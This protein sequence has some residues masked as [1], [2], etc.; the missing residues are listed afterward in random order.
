MIGWSRRIQKS[1]AEYV[2]RLFQ[3]PPPGYGFS[4]FTV[5][6]EEEVRQA[7]RGAF[8]GVSPYVFV[9]L[10]DLRPVRAAV[11]MVAVEFTERDIMGVELGRRLGSNYT[12]CY[13]VIGANR[14][15]REDL[16][17]FLAENTSGASIPIYDFTSGSG[18]GSQVGIGQARTRIR[19]EAL[20]LYSDPPEIEKSLAYWSAVWFEIV[21]ER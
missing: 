5:Y 12:F 4:P 11:P 1:V 14:G 15:Q 8:S 10:A 21:T 13:N 9:V 16:A 3:S 19:T 20:S 2:R 18:V 7:A 17:D 6:G